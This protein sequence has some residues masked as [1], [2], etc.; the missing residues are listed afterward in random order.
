MTCDVLARLLMLLSFRP[1]SEQTIKPQSNQIDPNIKAKQIFV[2]SLDKARSKRLPVQR[3]CCSIMAGRNLRLLALFFMLRRSTV[4]ALS[5]SSSSPLGSTTRNVATQVLQGT[6]P[7]SASVDLNKYNI[8]NPQAEWQINRV[9]QV[10]ESHDGR[11]ALACRNSREHFVDSV[12]V[13]FPRLIPDGSLGLNLE[14]I[15]GDGGQFGLTLISSLVHEGSA[16]ASKV[17]ILPGDALSQVRLRRRRSKDA[18]LGGN[19]DELVEE[20]SVSTECLSYDATVEALQQLPPPVHVEGGSSE[21]S[22]VV[23][24]K[25][26]RR[27]PRVN[28]KLKYPPSQ[29]EKDEVIEMFAGE[30]LRQGMLVRGVKLND[31]LAKRFDTKT[32]G[33]CGAG[34]LC[35]TCIVT[36]ESGMDVLNPQ[37]PA[38][39]QMLADNPRQRLACKAVV[40]YG[41]IE[42]EMVVRVNPRQWFSDSS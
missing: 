2:T 24:V 33:N 36:V 28:V 12:T 7:P 9:L 11:L 16:E 38:E 40:G 39:K 3:A 14:E 13:S 27:L 34:G 17:D 42:G 37:R 22:F 23:T 30:N 1:I 25:R 10:N 18:S 32:G 8:E 29:N 5:S 21:D 4:M 41:M 35:R 15:V 26:I 19:D 6:G 31:P 20:W